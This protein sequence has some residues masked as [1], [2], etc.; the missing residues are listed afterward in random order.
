MGAAPAQEPDEVIPPSPS[1]HKEDKDG[2]LHPT[3]LG[4][5]TFAAG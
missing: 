5:W 2:K 3:S 4:L 1:P